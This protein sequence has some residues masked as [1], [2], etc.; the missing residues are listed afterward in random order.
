M[1]TKMKQY[2][3]RAAQIL[4]EIVRREEARK[5]A[6]GNV[7][8]MTSYTRVDGKLYRRE[9]KVLKPAH[10]NGGGKDEK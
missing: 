4:A 5:A 6:Q 7:Y 8:K 9:G 10:P 2:I 1:F 3:D